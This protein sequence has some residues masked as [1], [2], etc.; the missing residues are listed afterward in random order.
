MR[1]RTHTNPYNYYEKM[2]PLLLN[3]IFDNPNQPLDLEIGFGRGQFLRHWAKKYLNRN[4]IGVEVRKNITEL[5]QKRI[6]D[7]QLVSNTHIIHGSGERLLADSLPDHC[8]DTIFIFHPDPW[9]KKKH[10]KRRLVRTN[11]VKLITQKLKPSGT[12]HV[13]TDVKIL[14][15]AMLDTLTSSTELELVSNH[16]FWKED[17]TSHWHDF[18]EKD[19]RSVHFNSFIK[20]VSA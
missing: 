9:F 12:L 7:T 13:S 20:K 6:C 5:L 2:Q 18:S 14:W 17:Y 11:T 15:D 3:Q 19:Q 16:H 1:I 8:L 10:H 4:I